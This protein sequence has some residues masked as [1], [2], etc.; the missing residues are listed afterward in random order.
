MISV[1]HANPGCMQVAFTL[2]KQPDYREAVAVQKVP[3]CKS[4][5]KALVLGA[6]MRQS[7]N[8]YHIYEFPPELQGLP[9]GN[10]GSKV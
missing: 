1:I 8:L 2:D 9:V 4:C 10:T 6:M 7:L 3:T 5:G